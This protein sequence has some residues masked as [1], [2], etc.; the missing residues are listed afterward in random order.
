LRTLT[1][2]ALSALTLSACGDPD[3]DDTGSTDCEPGADELCNGIDD[4]CDGEID[5]GDAVDASAWYADE[6]EDGY[7]GMDAPPLTTCADPSDEDTLYVSDNT[8]CDDDDPEINPD[9]LWFPDAD[10]DSF[11]DM[12]GD[13]IAQCEQPSGY[14]RD[15]TD[16]DD[17]AADVNP[18]EVERCDE[19]D[20]DCDGYHGMDDLDG[21]GFAGCDD[22]CD[23]EDA[24]INPDADETCDG[25]D[26]DCDGDDDEDDAT[27]AGTWFGDF[28]ADGYGDPRVTTRACDAPSDFVADATDCDDSDPAVN[29]AATEV[30]NGVDDD[31][32]GSVDGVS[33]VDA[34]DWYADDDLDGYGDPSDVTT[35]CS[36][37]SGT[38]ADATDCDDSDPD[39]NPGGT[40][41]CDGVDNDCDGTVDDDEDILGSSATCA[42][43]S[44]LDILDTRAVTPA[45]GRYYVDPTSSGYGM[46]IWCDMS[47]DGGGYSFLKVNYGR[48][49]EATEAESYCASNG[50]QLFIPR[51]Q[52]HQLAALE[53][54]RSATFGPSADDDYMRILG[55]YPTYNGATCYRVAFNSGACSDW[56]ASDGGPYWVGD[57]TDITEPNGDNTTTASMY[58]SWQS[59]GTVSWYN[60]IVSPGY[61]SQYFMC[62][63]GDKH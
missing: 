33:A 18:D 47:T 24:T 41:T 15:D 10:S 4:D 30:C 3:K 29:P 51:T 25:I 42:G 32:N 58:Y 16:C 35:A 9:T 52:E 23:D 28:D 6:D 40:E 17:D 19:V 46:Q 2:L 53:L 63:V 61:T 8:D 39:T 37:P 54:A 14:V 49:V 11:G 56:A 38:V 12:D 21:D 50:M 26:N 45:D 48:E 34:S 60:D 31:C 43:Y 13:G 20:H 57:R 22:D 44:C 1:L 55:I 62:D 59:D 5:E 27:D 36:A 7:G